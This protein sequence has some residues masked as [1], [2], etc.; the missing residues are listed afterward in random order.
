[1]KKYL[2][3]FLFTS[4]VAISSFCQTTTKKLTQ[5]KKD[6][7]TK[8]NSARADVIIINKKIITSDSSKVIISVATKTKGCKWKLK[9]KTNSSSQ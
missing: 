8:E 4:S 3:L 1:M 9:N 7:K 5:L 6:P 2:F